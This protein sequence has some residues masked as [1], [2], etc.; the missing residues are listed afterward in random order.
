VRLPPW[1]D[2]ALW[3][4]NG[5]VRADDLARAVEDARNALKETLTRPQR[6]LA[7]AGWGRWRPAA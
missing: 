5:G 7:A 1:A 6:L 3:S 2:A 4:G